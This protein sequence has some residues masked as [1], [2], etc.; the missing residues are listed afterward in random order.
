LCLLIACGSESGHV[1][2]LAILTAEDLQRAQSVTSV[3]TL[4]IKGTELER[5]SLPLRS[6]DTVFVADNARLEMLDLPELQTSGASLTVVSNPALVS[7]HLPALQ[8]A[9]TLVVQ[10]NPALTQVRAQKLERLGRLSVMGNHG[11][12]ELELPSLVEAVSGFVIEGALKSFRAPRA[13]GDIVLSSPALVE[14]EAPNAISRLGFDNSDRRLSD[15]PGGWLWTAR[16]GAQCPFALPSVVTASGADWMVRWGPVQ[17]DSG[18]VV[19]LTNTTGEFRSVLVVYGLSGVLG[20]FVNRADARGPN[21]A[22]SQHVLIRHDGLYFV[23]YPENRQ[24]DRVGGRTTAPEPIGW[25]SAATARRLDCPPLSGRPAVTL[26]GD[27]YP[28]RPASD[29][30]PDPRRSAPQRE[31]RHSNDPLAE[32]PFIAFTDGVSQPV[33]LMTDGHA[34][35]ACRTE[36]DC[37]WRPATNEHRPDTAVLSV[38]RG[39]VVVAHGCGVHLIEGSGGDRLVSHDVSSGLPTW[40]ALRP[41]FPESGLLYP[42]LQ[43]R[44]G[45]VL[46]V[47]S[48]RARRTRPT[49]D[50]T[51]DLVRDEAM[52]SSFVHL[53]RRSVITS[54][55]MEITLRDFSGGTELDLAPSPGGFMTDLEV[56]RFGTI[57]AWLRVGPDGRLHVERAFQLRTGDPSSELPL[58]KGLGEQVLPP[59][60][61]LFSF[62]AGGE[63]VLYRRGQ[64]VLRL[65]LRRL[66]G[67]PV[68]ETTFEHLHVV[69]MT[70]AAREVLDASRPAKPPCTEEKAP[71]CE[72]DDGFYLPVPELEG[73]PG[74]GVM[75]R[76]DQ[77]RP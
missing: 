40:C 33:P 7:L 72:F 1:E 12:I 28:A 66:P 73:W 11:L 8:R 18:C 55:R 75:E 70:E 49:N 27:P 46:E 22:F 32:P 61:R 44:V 16:N 20:W 21:P 64:E 4:I 59:S 24:T 37:R 56:A 10:Q 25:L 2:A 19:G 26:L 68:L 62:T 76:W 67:D 74:L 23:C 48:G 34:V 50:R 53:D 35:A 42:R 65:D 29:L 38:E 51:L 45:P 5:V 52:Y 17:I 39:R 77:W 54:L 57:H 47:F 60:V 63:L 13:A 31:A 30:A 71:Y 41:L 36:T 15:D 6:A 69:D 9:G 43:R 14:I 3:G 58:G